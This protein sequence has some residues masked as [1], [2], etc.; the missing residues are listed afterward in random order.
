MNEA[1][2]P[3]VSQSKFFW[4]SE[5]VSDAATNSNVILGLVPRTHFSADADHA[6]TWFRKQNR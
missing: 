1:F 6:V 3:V 4:L 5:P 2:P